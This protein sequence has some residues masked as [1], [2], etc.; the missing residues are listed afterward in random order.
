MATA[1]ACLGIASTGIYDR[2]TPWNHGCTVVI[3]RQ[4]GAIADPSCVARCEQ[5]GR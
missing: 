5:T 4:L 1:H 3:T 2:S